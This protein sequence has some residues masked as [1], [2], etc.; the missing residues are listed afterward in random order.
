M[1]TENKYIKIIETPHTGKTKG[2]EIINKSGNY[3]IGE[4][5]WYSNW[6]QYCLFT[7]EDMIFNSQCLE[8]INEFLKGINIEHRKSWK[9][10]K[11]EA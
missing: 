3:P 8:L 9:Q 11:E 6:R 2:F 4:I 10:K 7:W 1:E 5:Y